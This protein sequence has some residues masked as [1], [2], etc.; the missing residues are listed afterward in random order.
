MPAATPFRIVLDGT[1][2]PCLAWRK[3]EEGQRFERRWEDG[4]WAG[5][6]VPRDDGRPNVY[7][8]ANSIDTTSPPYIRL[9]PAFTAYTLDNA[10][11][12][13]FPAYVIGGQQPNTNSVVYIF[14]GSRRVKINVTDGTD[15]DD[16]NA[17]TN[18][19]R[20][21]LFEGSWRIPQ[22]SINNAYTLG[23]A[24]GATSGD[25]ETSMGVPA[26][27]FATIQNESVAQLARAFDTNR[28][29]LA[30]AI[31]GAA[32][33]F[34]PSSGYEVGDSSLGISD[35]LELQGELM[36]IKPDGPRKF[37]SLGNSRLV[38]KFVGSHPNASSFLG[39]NSH[40]HG[41]YTYWLHPSGIWRIVGDLM[42]PQTFE[43]QPYFYAFE[44]TDFDLSLR[45]SSVV[46]YGRWLYATRGTQLF[47]AYINDDGT[48]IWHGAI[49]NDSVALRV[50][51]TMNLSSGNPDLWL[52][53]SSTTLYRIALQ[54]DG[55]MRQ[56]LGTG[57][58]TQTNAVFRLPR[59][60]GGRIDRLK[61]LRRM[62]ITTEGVSGAT[63]LIGGRVRRDGGAVET[64][65][66]ADNTEGF[67][68]GV[69]TPGTNDTFREVEAQ[70]LMTQGNANDPRVRA[71]GLEAHTLDVYEAVIPLNPDT[72]GGFS[73]GIKGLLQS[74]RHL[75]HG[76]SLAVKEPEINSDFNGYVL[77]VRE[78]AVPGEGGRGIGYE[79]RVLIERA[80]APA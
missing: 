45:W 22:G 8:V 49:Q 69:L 48:L 3:V 57:R 63:A 78:K 20:P 53:T 27:H 52:M 61:Q 12:M 26:L 72:V 58:G 24:D 34:A 17:N 50:G 23:I 32:A 25:S 62:W 4:F 38:Q 44:S 64:I 56:A 5:M 73:G 46:A 71:I 30:E 11:G 2:Y 80:A 68:E 47:A 7:Y 10:L 19:G 59:W 60:D 70:V 76:A 51:I 39:A 28:I 16:N 31:T 67:R 13:A 43:A 21:A 42:S 37:D 75:Q 18:Y 40:A 6:G 66:T 9:W 1:E 33:D 54:S 14:N 74:L 77:S 15:S 41:T 55:S 29:N 65:L 79:V 36:V 35:L